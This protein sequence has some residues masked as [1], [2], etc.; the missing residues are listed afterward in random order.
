MAQR[1]E[2]RNL[3][4]ALNSASAALGVERWQLTYSVLMEKRGFL[5][6]VKRIVVEADINEAATQPVATSVAAAPVAPASSSPGGGSRERGARGRGGRRD[7]G[8]GG[9]RRGR[10]GRSRQHEEDDAF[11]SGD[12]EQFAVE[13]PEQGRE[14]EGAVAV[15]GWC[16]QLIALSKLELVVRTDENETQIRVRLYGR[17]SRKLTDRHGELL[18][19][20]QVLANK[21]LVGRQLDKDIELDTQEFKS[22]REEDLGQRARE[23]ADRVRREGREQLLPAMSPIE[24]RIVHLALQDD[25]EVATES[26]GDGFFKRVAVILRSEASEET[27]SA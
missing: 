11:Q 22:K 4:E 26:R 24:R 17:D 6:G 12:F 7:R 20:F 1:F 27:H 2:G 3:E 15:R 21:A 25:P 18:D 8:A 19:A 23:L 10:G 9:E 13:I 16:E 5:G 14:S